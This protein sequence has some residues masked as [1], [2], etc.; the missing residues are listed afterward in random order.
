MRTFFIKVSKPLFRHYM[1]LQYALRQMRKYFNALNLQLDL[2]FQLLRPKVV[3]SNYP[4]NL[5]IVFKNYKFSVVNTDCKTKKIFKN[6]E[7]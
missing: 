1:S 2:R 3:F 5:F 4:F 7:D 6:I